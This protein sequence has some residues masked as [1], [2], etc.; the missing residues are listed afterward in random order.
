MHDPTISILK[1]QISVPRPQAFRRKPSILG[2]LIALSA[3]MATF[4]SAPRSGRAADGQLLLSAVDKETGQPIACR[5]HLQNANGKPVK[6][7][8]TVAWGDHFDF[9]GKVLLKLPVG[10]YTFVMERGLEY[11]DMT[12]H[13]RI[14]H[15]ADDAKQVELRRFC[16][17]AKE[18]WWSGDLDIQRPDK[19]LPLLMQA[20]D[21][22]VAPL[23]TFSN[24]K[25]EWS[26]RALPAKPLIATEGNRYYHLLA[27]EDATPGGLLAY[28]QLR[29]PF[30]LKSLSAES[31][32]DHVADARRQEGAWIDIRSDSAWDLPVWV[33]L[34]KV[35]S[36]EVI[37]RQFVRDGGAAPPMPGDRPRDKQQFPP[38]S[39][40]GRWSQKVY[41][42]LL[43]CGLRIPPSAGSGSGVSTNPAG[44][45]RVYVY[46]GEQFSYE[47][48]WAG[49]RAGK[50]VVTNGPM[51]RPTVEGEPPGHVFKAG[52]GE[53]IDLEIGLTLS[54]R[55]KISYLEIIQDGRAIHQVRLDDWQKAGGKLP[56]VVFDKS[57]WFLV[58]AVADTGKT[59][60]FAMTA[61]YYVEIGDIPRISRSSAQFFV[62]WID[63]REKEVRIDDLSLRD[64]TLAEIHKARDYWKTIMSEVNAE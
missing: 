7:P 60:R 52:A 64:A 22:H 26:K 24:A 44:Y 12:G 56:H 17:M 4:A 45:N 32:L 62:D 6:M 13:F 51:L 54:T 42:H 11:L 38:P 43:N 36:I 2:W 5:I 21:L 25:S 40:I 27:G 61:P 18:G 10:N 46:C 9:G 53:K 63:E 29:E 20:E 19:D 30:D 3:L 33:A 15:F 8:G 47:G 39:G 48:W 37:D 1:S 35:D 28:L 16:N 34:G 55:D 58:R 59:S 23:T 31:P 41:F 50:V 57:G 49:L 14:E